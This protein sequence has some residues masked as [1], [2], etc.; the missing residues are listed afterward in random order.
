MTWINPPGQGTYNDYIGFV[1]VVTELNTGLIYYG[2]KTFWTDKKLPPLKGRTKKEKARR[3]KLK[4]QKRIV[5][6]ETDWRIYNTSNP[7]LMEAIP[8]NP[9][10]YRKRILTLCHTKTEMKAIE[11]FYQLQAYI[12]GD[13]DHV[14]NE[15]INLRLRIR[16]NTKQ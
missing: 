10:N 14:L 16:K 12:Q 6:R 11:A 2:I 3:A 5:R 15:V 1:Y 13:W 8:K 4:G 7:Y 9:G